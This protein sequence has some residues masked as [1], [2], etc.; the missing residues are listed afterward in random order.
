M[1]LLLE[2]QKLQNFLNDENTLKCEYKVGFY[3]I[4]M[5]FLIW[6]ETW[7]FSVFTDLKSLQLSSYEQYCLL[8]VYHNIISIFFL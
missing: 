2:K 6:L 5:I 3:S 4:I 7:W 1:C 8:T